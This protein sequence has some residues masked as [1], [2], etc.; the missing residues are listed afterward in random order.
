[1]ALPARIALAAVALLA[2]PAAAG[3][4]EITKLELCGPDGCAGS[5]DRQAIAPFASDNTPAAPSGP[6]AYYELRYTIVEGSHHIHGTMFWVPRPNRLRSQDERG[7]AAW[8]ESGPR[9]TSVL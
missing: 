2:L 3:A 6:A 8:M 7:Y 1:M 4:K 5:S 9:L